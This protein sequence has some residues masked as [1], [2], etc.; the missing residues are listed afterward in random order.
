MIRSHGPAQ[1]SFDFGLG[2]VGWE[3]SCWDVSF[4]VPSK[5]RWA[6]GQ[7][8]CERDGVRMVGSLEELAE[9]VVRMLGLEKGA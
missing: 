4:S 5:G 3:V 7:V 6:D 8:V 9:E 2:R 1:C